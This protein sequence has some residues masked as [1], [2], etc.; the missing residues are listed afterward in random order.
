MHLPNVTAIGNLSHIG[1][2]PGT[3]KAKLL[4]TLKQEKNYQIIMAL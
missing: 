2:P 3:I 1:L 4:S